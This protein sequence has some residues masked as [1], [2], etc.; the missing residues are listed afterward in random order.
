MTRLVSIHV[1]LEPELLERYQARAKADDRP[2]ASAIRVAL[3]E[4]ERMRELELVKRENLDWLDA[5]HLPERVFQDGG[6]YHDA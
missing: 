5:R 2:L 1:R 3:W 6:F 4:A